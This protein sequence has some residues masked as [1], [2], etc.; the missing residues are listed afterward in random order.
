[1]SSV[2]STST[3][4]LLQHYHD[5]LTAHFGDLHDARA[6][7]EPKSPV[8][9]L[10]H[11]LSSADL[12]L[13]MGAVREGIKNQHLTRYHR[14]WLPFVVYATEIGYDYVGDEYW[15]TF[16][17]LTPRWTS[18]ERSTVRSWFL[19]FHDQFGGACPTGA[20]ARHFTIIAWP[21]PMPCFRFTFSASWPNCS[22]SSGRA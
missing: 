16:E 8:F 14:T 22:T 13:L 5:V 12:D 7:L 15:T 3:A 4:E 10:E 17:S 21:S 1:M 18:Q 9:A 19:R 6:R 20:W 2:A 11:D